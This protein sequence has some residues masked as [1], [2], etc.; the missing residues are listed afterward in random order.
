MA[1]LYYR[2]RIAG[3]PDVCDGYIYASGWAGQVTLTRGMFIY[4]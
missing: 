1:I 4:A 2:R 3:D